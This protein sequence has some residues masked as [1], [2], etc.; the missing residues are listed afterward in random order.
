VAAGLPDVAVP[1]RARLAR[2][3]STILFHEAA[4]F[5]RNWVDQTPEKYGE[6]V[7]AHL[8]RGLAIPDSEYAEA[9]AERER[10]RE[11]MAR[12]MEG[13]DA[14]LL[15]ATYVVAPRLEDAAETRDQLSGLTRPFNVTGQPVICL[16]AP[17][18]PGE[19]PVGVQVVGHPDREAE[20]VE[21][22]RAFEGAWR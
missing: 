20:L 4:A 17:V 11:E 19:L 22:A 9:L 3:G 8:R 10:L 1:D 12:A 18:R 5:H 21:V 16:P 6:D 15:P 2:C 7:L 13:L 14:L